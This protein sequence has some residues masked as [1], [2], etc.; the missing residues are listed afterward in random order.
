MSRRNSLF[1]SVKWNAIGLMEIG[2][3]EID[4]PRSLHVSLSAVRRPWNEFISEGCVSR[5]T[6]P[7]RPR[8]TKP[9]F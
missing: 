9:A 6:V 2:L 3:S 5:R 4:A 1:D 8:H 7:G